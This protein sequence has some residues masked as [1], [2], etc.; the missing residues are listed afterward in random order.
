MNELVKTLAKPHLMHER[1]TRYGE[2]TEEEYYDL[3]PDELQEFV[4]KIVEEVLLALSDLKGYSGVGT[5][6]NPYCTASW[7][8]ALAAAKTLILERLNTPSDSSGT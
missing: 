8:A 4:V 5:D 2:S 1:W 3:Y 7:N 6:G